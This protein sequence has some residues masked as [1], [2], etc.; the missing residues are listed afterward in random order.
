[1][2][3]EIEIPEPL[4]EVMARSKSVPQISPSLDELGHIVFDAEAPTS[5]S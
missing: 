5:V 4:A 2:G 3:Q 1:V